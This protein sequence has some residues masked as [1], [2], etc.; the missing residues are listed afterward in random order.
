MFPLGS[1]GLMK[2]ISRIRLIYWKNIHESSLF[3][4]LFFAQYK[5][6]LPIL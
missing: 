5:N 2:S 3:H 6:Y 1:N 4:L